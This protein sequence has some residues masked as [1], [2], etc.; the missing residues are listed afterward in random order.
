MN[1][2]NDDTINAYDS[3]VQAYLNQSPGEMSDGNFKDWL[4]K[5]IK[6]LPTSS[7][8]FEIG[9]GGGR[10]AKYI[11]SKGYRVELTDASI[12]FVNFLKDAGMKAKQFN[13][14]TDDFNESYDLILANAVLLHFTE[15]QFRSVLIKIHDAL[16]QNGRF[17][18]VLKQGDG[19]FTEDKKLGKMRYF[20]M[21]QEDDLKKVLSKTGLS[22]K[23]IDI[24]KHR[25][26]G[27]PSWIMI[28]AEKQQ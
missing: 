15:A 22:I 20:H 11:Q 2:T 1:V 26:K 19:D 21:W 24:G 3:G 17:A 23:S 12:G 27:W 10:D 18:F 5:A 14:L 28:V 6:D 25:K 16:N 8:I 9:S 13:V 7:K 4:D